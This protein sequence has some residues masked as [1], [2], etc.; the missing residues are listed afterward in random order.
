[1]PDRPPDDAWIGATSG[2]TGWYLKIYRRWDGIRRVFAEVLAQRV[3]PDQIGA[4]ARQASKL[5]G[6]PIRIEDLPHTIAYGELATER[7][8]DYALGA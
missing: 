4:L 8:A 6:L 3:R 1:M 7:V 5:Y 2:S